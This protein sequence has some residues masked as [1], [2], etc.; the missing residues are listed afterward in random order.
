VEYR[1]GSVSGGDVGVVCIRLLVVL[2]VVHPGERPAAGVGD[3]SRR[4][5]R[6]APLVIR[7]AGP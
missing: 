6:S 1:L 7:R 4:L 2:L 5:P 3:K